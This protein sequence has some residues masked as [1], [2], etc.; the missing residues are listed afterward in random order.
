M[1]KWLLLSSVFVLCLVGGVWAFT[2]RQFPQWQELFGPASIEPVTF[3]LKKGPFTIEIPALGELQ[4]ASSTAISVPMVRTGGLK[5]FWI[6]K[7]GSVVRKGDTLV[8]FDASEL[9]TQLTDSQNSLEATLR[10][11]EVTVLRG[12][13]DT[14]QIVVDRDIAGMELEKAQTQAP[15]DQ[16]IFTRNQILEGE[17]DIGLSGTRVR[18]LGGK[19]ESKKSINSTAQRILVIDRSQHENR[20]GML[21]QSLGS[22]KIL[23]PHDGLV[24]HVKDWTGQ[25]IGVGDTRWPGSTIL[26]IPDTSAIKARVFVL[27]ADAGN[28]KVGQKARIAVDSHPAVAFDGKVERVDTLARPIERESPVKYF[29][30]I[31]QILGKDPEI[32][33]P[34]KLVRVRIIAASLAE[35]LVV[36]RSALTE[37][38]RKFYVWIQR[39]PAVEKRE[40][41][42]GSGDAARIVLRAGVAA[43]ELVLLN[44]PRSENKAEREKDSPAPAASEGRSNP[45]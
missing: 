41:E 20:R 7:D 6:V 19:V 5:V 13:S 17:L 24:L 22:L 45:R 15:Q 16:E 39:G 36:P 12:S 28:L 42:I 33:K 35:T 23:S 30:A 8:E 21:E 18:E 40:V 26:T 4:T 31:L 2:S 1:K 44:P 11:L 37:E 14:G 32:L 27:E 43:G 29:E 38:G 10:Q 34:G 25:G 9:L 3:S